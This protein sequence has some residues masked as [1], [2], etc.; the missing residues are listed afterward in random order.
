MKS[1]NLLFFL[2][3]LHI[4][5]GQ[6]T[7]GYTY[8]KATADGTGKYYMGREI[9]QVM[10]PGGIDW[11]ERPQRQNEENTRLAISKMNLA[12]GA[13]V[14]DIG[15][16]SGY[17]AFRIASK[18]PE[19]KVYAVEV[20]HE[21]ISYLNK[22]KK[23]IRAN[24]VI[25]VKGDSED[26]HLPPASIDL[27]IMVDVYHELSW[28]VEVVRSI[29]KS[30]KPSGKILLIEYRG[31]D[32]AVPIRELHKTTIRQVTKEFHA[33]DFELDYRGEFLPI[34]HFLVFRKM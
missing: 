21:M 31:E 30:L 34:Q 20:Q 13:V 17:Y 26:V 28:P 4:A 10:G 33:A 29:R 32:P 18:V 15:A 7:S 3:S 27:A 14:A 16:G 11:L 23:E 19:G 12:P 9:A 2:L 5:K 8:A 24:N 1:I 25:V 6:E 22:K